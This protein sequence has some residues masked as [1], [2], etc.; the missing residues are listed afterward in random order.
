MNMKVPGRYNKK[1]SSAKEEKKWSKIDRSSLVHNNN[2]NNSVFDQVATEERALLNKVG[3][4]LGIDKWENWYTVTQSQLIDNGVGS[5][6]MSR[7]NGSPAS[8]IQSVY[9]EHPWKLWQFNSVPSRYWSKKEHIHQFLDSLSSTL[10]ITQ[11]E[12]WYAVPLE[13]FS[14]HGGGGLLNLHNNSPRNLLQHAYPQHPWRAWKFHQTPRAYWLDKENQKECMELLAKELNI[15]QMEDWYQIPFAKLQYKGA[16]G[17]LRLYS[18][19]PAQLIITTYPQYPWKPWKFTTAP[20]HFWESVD[21][22][23]LFMDDLA[24]HL[25]LGSWED[26]YAVS[27]QQIIEHGGK[28]LLQK[29]M[30]S[31]S[32]LLQ[33]VYPQH[34]WDSW[35]FG[36]APKNYWFN[37]DHHRKY[38]EWLATEL[39]ITNKDGW[40][41]VTPLQVIS[42]GGDR[43]LKWY[44]GLISNMM[45][46]IYPDYPWKVW[47]FHSVPRHYWEDKQHQTE[48]VEWLFTEL[49]LSDWKDWYRVP[50]VTVSKNGGNR[51]LSLYSYSVIE[52]VRQI[53]PQHPWDN[54]S[55]EEAFLKCKQ[56]GKLFSW[57]DV[58]QQGL[59]QLDEQDEEQI[60]IM[61]SAVPVVCWT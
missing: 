10:D 24:K 58:Y 49:N 44:G 35:N 60:E 32:A 55:K 48:F 30:S 3:Q 56:Q 18:N 41:E 6:L 39:G 25:D 43:I 19:S 51:L 9:P 42:N 8:L 47:R 22:Q 13:E 7:Y 50:L 31:P 34:P 17:L 40:Y 61:E 11:W 16:G 27:S 21:N 1:P 23:R 45:Q 29:F 52:L 26:W 20:K 28:A 12:D 5:L 46:S 4:K 59:G 33:S 2:N 38:A 53:Y 14:R 15:K 37:K 54:Q 36:R 57:M